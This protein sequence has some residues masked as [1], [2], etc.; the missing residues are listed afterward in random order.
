MLYKFD[1]T[2]LILTETDYYLQ[3]KRLHR[4]IGSLP[5]FMIDS[6]EIGRNIPPFI[7]DADFIFSFTLIFNHIDNL[8]LG[9]QMLS[10][11]C[12]LNYYEPDEN[13]SISNFGS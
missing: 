7:E 2:G 1:I 5:D 12:Y 8:E 6:N 10:A 13:P 9:L 3:T 4:F 11:Y